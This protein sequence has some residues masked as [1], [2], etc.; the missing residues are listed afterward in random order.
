MSNK[1]TDEYLEVLKEYEE[2]M[3]DDFKSWQDAEEEIKDAIKWRDKMALNYAQSSIRYY[4]YKN[5]E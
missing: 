3:K 5:R 4:N 2:D 1:Q